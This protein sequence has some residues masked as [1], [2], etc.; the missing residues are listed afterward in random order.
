MAAV[1]AAVAAAAAFF[2]VLYK[3][4]ASS[5]ENASFAVLGK[6][7]VPE[8]GGDD[9]DHAIMKILANN[10]IEQ[11]GPDVLDTK[12][13]QGISKKKLR[14]AIQILKEKAEEAKIELSEADSA[15]IDAPNLVKDENGKEY[16]I[17]TEITREQFEE[18][19]KPLIDQSGECIKQALS[20]A[21]LE[22]DDIDRIILVGGSTRVPCIR[23]LVTE[24]FGK[25]PYGDIDAATAV[26]QGAA[27]VGATFELPGEKR[28]EE[29]PREPF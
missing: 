9:F 15:F 8:L 10:L 14:T 1:G 7:G 16:H 27:I 20:E 26:S 12:K 13:D 18:A 5:G 23:T 17:S 29:E 22:E 28:D 21:K 6:A 2:E 11:G 4:D 25:E 19:I 3:V 24:M